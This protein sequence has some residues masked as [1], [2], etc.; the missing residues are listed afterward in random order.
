MK[1]HSSVVINGIIYSVIELDDP[2]TGCSGTCDYY[3]QCK[4][5]CILKSIVGCDPISYTLKIAK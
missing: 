1:K 2:K 5:A 4:G 3:Y